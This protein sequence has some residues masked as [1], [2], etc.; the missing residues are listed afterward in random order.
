MKTYHLNIVIEGD[1]S[2]VAS[3]DSLDEL[4]NDL[5]RDTHDFLVH[6]WGGEFKPDG[7]WYLYFTRE[8]DDGDIQELPPS[9]I[10][11]G[12]A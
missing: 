3:Y 11:G 5:V 6:W 9:E 1:D 2:L 8:D 4:R 10:L 7:D 12:A